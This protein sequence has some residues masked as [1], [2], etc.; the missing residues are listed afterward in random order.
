MNKHQHYALS[1]YL[2]EYNYYDSFT[3]VLT[4]IKLG[5]PSVTIAD[6]YASW[7]ENQLINRIRE[8]AINLAKN[9]NRED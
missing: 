7:T 9:Y 4:Q 5:C 1:H 3:D 6:D 8:M 2:R